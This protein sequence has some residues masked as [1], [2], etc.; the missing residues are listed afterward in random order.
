MALNITCNVDD[1][2]QDGSLIS[3][4][5][6]GSAVEEDFVRGDINLAISIRPVKPSTT[7]TRPWD[8][9]FITGDAFQVSIGNLDVPPTDGTFD[10]AALGGSV[11]SSSVANPSVI[12]HAASSVTLASGNTVYISGHT[13]STPDIN[14]AHVITVTDSTH[15]TIPVNVTVG[16]TGGSFYLGTGLAGIAFDV[17][18]STLAT[19]LTVAPFAA[20]TVTDVDTTGAYIAQWPVGIAAP[21]FVSPGNALDPASQVSVI[22]ASTSSNQIRA[23]DLKQQ[24]VAY[25]EPSTLFPVAGVTATVKQSGSSTQNKIYT[26]TMDVAGTYGGSFSLS[27]AGILISKR[28]VGIF[29]PSTTAQTIQAAFD[30]LSN[31][32]TP[33]GFNTG[34]SIVSK[35]ADGVIAIELVDTQGL[36]N[37]PVISITNIDLIAPHGVSG[38]MALNTTNLFRAFWNTTS[39]T[40]NFTLEIRRTRAS[41]E[42]S[43][44]FQH[45]VTLKRNLID[46]V[47]VPTVLP[48]YDTVAQRNAAIAAAISGLFASDISDLGTMATQNANAIAVTGGT[49]DALTITNTT[50]N[51][52]GITANGS[53]GITLLM[54]S[55]EIHVPVNKVVS[56]F[57]SISFTGDD[58]AELDIGPGGMLGTGAFAATVVA[59]NPTGSIGL[60][61]VNGSAATFLRSDGAPAISQAIVPTWTGSHTWS[62]AVTFNAALT[63]SP[64]SGTVTFN[65]TTTGVIS[66]FAASLTT[67]ATSSLA[68]LIGGLKLTYSQKTAGYSILATDYAIELTANTATFTLPT[69]VG[70]LGQP[71]L[72]ANSGA[73]VL[74][75]STSGGQTINGA[76]TISIPQNASFQVTSNGANWIISGEYGA[77]VTGVFSTLAASGAV[78]FTAGAATSS[79][80]TGTVVV[81]GGIGASGTIWAAGNLTTDGNLNSAVVGKGVTIKGGTG[82]RI[83]AV[84]LSGGTSGAISIPSITTSSRPYIQRVTAAGTLGAGGYDYTISAGTSLTINSVDITGVLSALDT[85]TVSYFLVEQT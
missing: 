85:S 39:A 20:P 72:A 83:G 65:P 29:T 58:S 68:S 60:T 52:L 57:S 84:A 40:L 73:G 23:I 43:A 55:T 1:P 74:T 77:A 50:I 18:P 28:T 79:S 22:D 64:A 41:G 9:D 53:V 35:S 14:G 30:D 78:T 38:T 75:L 81:T 13:G 10:L 4:D 19:T 34:Q 42:Q 54:G 31:S 8:D 2:K 46:G 36:S 51:G 45:Q 49:A 44:I 61:A 71:F 62:A 80:T 70:R 33:D 37:A 59:A 24:P 7:T 3:F 5:G 12:T 21:T 26:V 32:G 25:A 16:G 56:F 63:C 66:N 76:S 67:L 69:A 15:F 11:T 47:I 82:G 6:Q 17:S 48:I 27:Y